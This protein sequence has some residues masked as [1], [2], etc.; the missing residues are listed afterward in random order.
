LVLDQSLD[1]EEVGLVHQCKLEKRLGMVAHEEFLLARKA[2]LNE[3][4]MYLLHFEGW[5][6]TDVYTGL[7]WGLPDHGHGWNGV[8]SVVSSDDVKE[9]MS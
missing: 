1:N 6:A 8:H 9:R 2:I 4:C 5:P 7:D 3:H